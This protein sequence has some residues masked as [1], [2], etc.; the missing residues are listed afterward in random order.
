MAGKDQMW[1]LEKDIL[2][3]DNKVYS[4]RYCLFVPQEVNAAFTFSCKARGKY[5]IGV[6][7]N[8]KS[9][10]LEAFARM[11]N[12]REHLGRS[13]DAKYLHS[14]WQKAKIAHIRRLADKYVFHKRLYD[15]LNSRADDIQADVDNNR[16]SVFV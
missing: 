6:S 9:S 12:G 10:I 7:F 14:L 16:E 3:Q 13:Q 8:K 5:P 1:H 4:P 15:A 2:V 11:Q